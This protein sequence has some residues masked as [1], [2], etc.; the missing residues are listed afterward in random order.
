MAVERLRGLGFIKVKQGKL[1]MTTLPLTTLTDVPSA[2]RNK[3]HKQ[4]L[5]LAEKSIDR[6]SVQIRQSVSVTMAI[7]PDR[8]GE[9]KKRILQFRDRLAN[10]LDGK[11]AKE[12]CQQ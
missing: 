7:D 1:I 12:V 5:H 3:Y 2:A 10:S 4:N 8:I 9:A 6:D 11:K